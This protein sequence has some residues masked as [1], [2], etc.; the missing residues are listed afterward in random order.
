MDFLFIDSRD[1]IFGLIVL[2]FSILLVILLSY[3]WG[4][5]STKQNREQ[6]DKFLQKFAGNADKNKILNALDGLDNS[7]LI[8]IAD[9]LAK[10][11]DWQGAIVFYEKV[12]KKSRDIK[13]KTAVLAQL[14]NAY[15]KTGFLERAKQSLCELLRIFPR[16]EKALFSLIFVCEKLRDFNLARASL[17][18]LEAI[19]GANDEISAYLSALEILSSQKNSATKLAELERLGDTMLIRRFILELS[20]EL[21]KDLEGLKLPP[22]ELCIDLLGFDATK[23]FKEDLCNK[24]AFNLRLLKEC[25]NSKIPAKLEFS[26]ICKECSSN[27]P[28]FFARCPKCLSIASIKVSSNVIFNEEKNEENQDF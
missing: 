18:A 4:I 9:G 7:E 13:L 25:Q 3:F 24:N 10:M 27:Y 11:G 1:P 8:S 28:L 20:L 17:E 26:Y 22:L 5:L 19:S 6:I 15:I 12:I 23:Y 14:A 2:V 16:D 21:G